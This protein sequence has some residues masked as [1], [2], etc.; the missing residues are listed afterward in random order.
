[1]RRRFAALM[2]TVHNGMPLF[3]PNRSTGVE[4]VFPG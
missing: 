2:N 3:A 1:M 4:S